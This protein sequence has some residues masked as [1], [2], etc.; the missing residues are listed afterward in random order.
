MLSRVLRPDAG[1]AK[2]LLC[3]QLANEVEA[4]GRPKTRKIGGPNNEGSCM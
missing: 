3:D 2:S 1:S 4:D